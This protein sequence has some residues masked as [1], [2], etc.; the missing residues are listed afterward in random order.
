MF[1]F[2]LFETY[3]FIFVSRYGALIDNKYLSL[4]YGGLFGT[5]SLINVSPNGS[6]LITN[7][8]DAIGRHRWSKTITITFHNG[9]YTVSRFQSTS[10]DTLILNS[11]QSCDYNLF[12]GKGIVNGKS[13]EVAPQHIILKNLKESQKFNL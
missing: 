6:L 11:Q 7:Q 9:E 10:Y 8:N 3:C 4:N 13:F 1:P 12:T 5:E 2:V